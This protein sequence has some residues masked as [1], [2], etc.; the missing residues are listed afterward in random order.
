MTGIKM[1]R[2]KEVILENQEKLTKISQGKVANA[3]HAKYLE[4]AA[5]RWELDVQAPVELF[6]D[7]QNNFVIE[8]LT[9]IFC[10]QSHQNL[11]YI[12]RVLLGE[13]LD[14]VIADFKGE[15]HI[16]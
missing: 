1:E 15:E 14:L 5:S 2:M 12:L 3:R 9:S 4:S 13:S 10:K 16:N 7:D 8:V 6:T 11:D